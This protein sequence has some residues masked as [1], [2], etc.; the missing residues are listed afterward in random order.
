MVAM[1]LIE[2]MFAGLLIAIL[3]ATWPTPPWRLLQ[4]G[5]AGVMVLGPLLL[6]PFTKTL[7]L[8]F[9]LTFRP[10]QR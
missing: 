3:L 5:G 2:L 10:D 9:D 6:F 1:I 8:A 4:W 7:Y